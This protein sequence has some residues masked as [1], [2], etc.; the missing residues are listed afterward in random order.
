VRTYGLLMPELPEVEAIVNRLRPEA[1]GSVIKRVEVLRA[2]STAPQKP[3]LLKEAIGRRIES[4]ERR[5]K[6]LILQLS[7][8][9]ALRIHLRMSGILRAIPDARLYA[10]STRVLFTLKDGRGI[11]FEDRRV[12]G[13]VHFHSKAEL[14]QKLE[15]IGPEPMTKAFTA[16]YLIDAASRSIRPIKIF[17]MDQHVVAGLGNIYAAEAL[18]AAKIHPALSANRV[19]EEKLR[20]LHAS[21][22]KVLKTAMN[23]AAKTF[24]APDRH[25]GMRFKVYG[26]KNEPCVVCAAGIKTL[27]QG[28]RTTY[29]CANCQRK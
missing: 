4:V 2:R 25:E 14:E 21:I 16:K 1:V 17:L 23:N 5:G 10:A 8:G 26:R 20:A 22:P 15:K 12:L 29:F 7:R 3:S 9:S 11:A 13:T 18:F 19:S 24:K 28:G 27:T 6:N